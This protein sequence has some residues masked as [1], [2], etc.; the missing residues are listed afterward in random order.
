MIDLVNGLLQQ[1]S[2]FKRD[3]HT[4]LAKH[5]SSVSRI[6]ALDE[7]RERLDNLSL[8]QD[9][10]FRQSLTCIEH[11]IYRAA[12]VMAWAAFV[13]CMEEKL[14]SDGLAKVKAKRAKWTKSIGQNP[15][16][17]PPR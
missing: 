3:A 8:R 15:E 1:I 12:H 14:A 16:L 6:V 11:E 2:A 5:E 17:H 13:D 9:D 7:T 10:L 4:I